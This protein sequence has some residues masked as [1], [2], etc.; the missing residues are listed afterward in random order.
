VLG[1]IAF[2]SNLRQTA[3]ARR[4]DTVA[5]RRHPVV[6]WEKRTFHR[7]DR[8]RIVKRA[9]TFKPE[10]TRF[11]AE[12]EAGAGHLGTILAGERRQS[13]DYMTIDPAEPVQ[14]VRVRWDRQRWAV[15]DREQQVDLDPFEATIHVS[16]LEVV[17]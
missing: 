1:A 12:I 2:R 4:A 10:E 15:Y 5:G 14:I 6:Q 17:R 3:Q 11:S 16:Y 9:G 8:V 7:G 13:T